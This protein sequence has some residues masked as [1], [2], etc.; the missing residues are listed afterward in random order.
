MPKGETS[1]PYNK[2]Y[3]GYAES[4]MS[5]TETSKTS[6]GTRKAMAGAGPYA[7]ALH[8]FTNVQPFRGGMGPPPS[9]SLIN[10]AIGAKMKK[11]RGG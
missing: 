9:Q 4:G 1:R 11:K 2:K 8:E 6:E 10:R 5:M 3:R 7:P